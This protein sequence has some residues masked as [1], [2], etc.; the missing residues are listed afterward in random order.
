MP[1]PSM[2]PAVDRTGD[3][4]SAA[5]QLMDWSSVR[6][7]LRDAIPAMR[8]QLLQQRR[9]ER[10]CVADRNVLFHVCKLPHTDDRGAA[11]GIRQNEAQ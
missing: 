11:V 4:E 2:R 5:R 7:P 3:A 1:H 6:P 10:R 9:I 8:L